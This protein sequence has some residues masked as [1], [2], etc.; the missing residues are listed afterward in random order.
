M[1][2]SILNF[3]PHETKQRFAPFQGSFACKLL[4]SVGISTISASP[5]IVT[6]CH[7]LFFPAP[8]EHFVFN[9]IYHVSTPKRDTAEKQIYLHGNASR[10]T[11]FERWNCCGHPSAVCSKQ[12]HQR[13]S[14]VPQVLKCKQADDVGEEKSLFIVLRMVIGAS[15][16]LA[17]ISNSGALCTV[18]CGQIIELVWTFSPST[19]NIADDRAVKQWRWHY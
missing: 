14:H 10:A 15:T 5:D 8:S 9:F 13:S 4:A 17:N 2:F 11:Q 18:D 16:S 7:I 12:F 6:F 1:K 3:P 19:L